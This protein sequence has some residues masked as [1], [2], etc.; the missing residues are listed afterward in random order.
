MAGLTAEAKS[1]HDCVFDT[2]SSPCTGKSKPPEN[3]ATNIP[4]NPPQLFRH[5][6][7][8]RYLDHLLYNRT[9]AIAMKPQTREAVGW[10]IYDCEQ[11]IIV[12]WDRDAEPPTLRGGDPKASGLVLLKSDIITLETLEVK[13]RISHEDSKW[14]L[15]SPNATV[16]DEYALQP[17]KR[18]THGAKD[19]K[20]ADET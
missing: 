1:S 19:S 16:N 12:A 8:V 20:R 2:F 5:L 4:L 6:I 3:S 14:V 7:L 11:Y 10:L 13:V 17:K 15:N 9:S 18:K